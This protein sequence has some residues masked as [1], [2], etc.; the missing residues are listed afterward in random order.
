SIT[1]SPLRRL[2][3]AHALRSALDL[4]GQSAVAAR[5][6][7]GYLD[8]ADGDPYWRAPRSEARA[9]PGMYERAFGAPADTVSRGLEFLAE[10]RRDLP[11]Q[12]FI[13]VLS[14]YLVPPELHVW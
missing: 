2:D 7:T 5:S 4:I 6:L 13:F 12:A 1:S 11:T 8:Y 9:G 10:H 3:K 14:D